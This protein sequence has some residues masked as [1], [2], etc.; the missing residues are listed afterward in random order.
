MDALYFGTN[1]NFFREGRD[2]RLRPA[3]EAWEDA[4]YKLHT[5]GTGRMRRIDSLAATICVGLVMIGAWLQ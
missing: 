1:L 2:G 3:T 5:P 4:Y